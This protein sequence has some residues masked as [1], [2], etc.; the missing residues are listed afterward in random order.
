M[1]PQLILDTLGYSQE[2]LALALRER[3]HRIGQTGI[4]RWVR[5]RFVHDR[6]RGP[7]D[8]V[9]RAENKELPWKQIYEVE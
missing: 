8:D 2:R 3:G 4:S 5:T 6:W 7:L 9:A 1:Q